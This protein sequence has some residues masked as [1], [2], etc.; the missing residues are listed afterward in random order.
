[1]R[2]SKLHI[3]LSLK[4]FFSSNIP[5]TIGIESKDFKQIEKKLPKRSFS[6]MTLLILLKKLIQNTLKGAEL[7][8][9][10]FAKCN[11]HRYL[12]RKKYD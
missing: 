12:E 9:V 4:C 10:L 5:Y 1:M 11:L 8:T 7:P 2:L 6:K 3:L